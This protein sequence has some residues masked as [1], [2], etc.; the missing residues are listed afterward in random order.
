MSDLIITERSNVVA[1][2]DSIRNKTGLTK[3]LTLGEMID[4]I[5]S[6]GLNDS[7]ID[8]S[9][10]TA[11]ADDILI[12]KT[13]YA[14][15]E[16]IIGTFSLDAE[17]TTQ[18]DIISQIQNALEG[19]TIGGSPEGMINAPEMCTVTL[20]F[21]ENSE[22]YTVNY[23]YLGV[24]E[25]TNTIEY[26]SVQNA[27]CG[28]S[29]TISCVKHS[30]IEISSNGVQDSWG[31]LDQSFPQISVDSEYY[32]GGCGADRSIILAPVWTDDLFLNI[33]LF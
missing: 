30:A 27:P 33:E 2:A 28:V 4:Y 15:D 7:G 21:L 20:N 16:K 11:T 23:L 8:T 24:N 25:D 3:E 26:F 19:K 1:V 9:D 6:F 32:V 22:P 29:H 17:I 5:E 13:A 12:G 14:N 31:G 10:A 18:D